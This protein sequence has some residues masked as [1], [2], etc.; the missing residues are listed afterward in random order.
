V[1]APP[2]RVWIDTDPAVGVPQRDVD[3]GFALLQAFRSDDLNIVGV[4]SVFGN[5]PLEQAHPITVALTDQWQPGT[6]VFRGAAG[7]D[8]GPTPASDALVEALKEGPLTVL[9]LGP[10]S[11]VAQ[12][13]KSR[14]DLAQRLK[15]VAVAGRLPGQR[16][17]TG[18]TNLRGHRDFN[19][20]QDPQAMAYLIE[21]GISL[22]LAPFEL[23]RKVW[24][25]VPY[26]DRLEAQAPDTAPLIA[27]ARAWLQ[28]WH[29]TFQVDG[30]NPFDTLAVGVLTRRDLITCDP[31]GVR[32]AEHPDDRT[33][34]EMQ[35][36]EPPTKPYL[37]VGPLFGLPVQWCHDVDAPRF[38]DALEVVFTHEGT[39]PRV[40]GP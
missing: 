14:P 30:F 40:D 36:T 10:V 20:E 1:M 25:T 24:I 12:A 29:D 16:F 33:A 6:P 26:L 37:E 2:L 21:R 19:F 3:D 18:T 34:P 23:S 22:T 7:P 11:N 5:A 38:L 28:L 35:G 17:T 31:L 27:P 32:I 8:E 13:V 9:A 4:S 15:V 39:T